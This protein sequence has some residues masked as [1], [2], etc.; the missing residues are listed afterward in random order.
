MK[1]CFLVA[2]AGLCL[3]ASQA[4]AETVEEILAKY[5]EARGGEEA[6]ANVETI[7]S[8]GKMLLGGGLEAPVEY[9][10]KSPNRFRFEMTMQGA[11]EISTFDG[12]EGFR[13]DLRNGGEPSP[14]GPDDYRQLNDAIDFMGPLV[15]AEAKGHKVELLG[16]EE[17]EGTP[18]W[19]LKLT[20]A[21]GDVEHIY[22]DAEYFIEIR[23]VELHE[24]GGR[25][26]EVE[27]TWGDYKEVGGVMI[28][29][30]WS[31]T[32][33]GGGQGLNVLFDGFTVNEKLAD[34]RFTQSAEG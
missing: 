7:R 22:L 9:E 32:P 6:L 16:Q 31:Q 25:T 19:K 28:P 1:K 11:T 10:W 17:V 29:H 14:M 34:D 33:P 5:A 2:A 4:P 18:A 24:V 20:K 15:N 8:S 26:V 3:F 21:N 27:V 30:S 13:S 12:K 23:Q